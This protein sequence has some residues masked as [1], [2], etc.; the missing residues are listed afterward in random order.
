MGTPFTCLQRIY[1]T[2]KIWRDIPR[3][4]K[5]IWRY[6]LARFWRMKRCDIIV[7][8]SHTY[9]HTRI[10]TLIH[11]YYILVYIHT[12]YRRDFGGRKGVMYRVIF[13]VVNQK[14]YLTRTHMHIYTRTCT[15]E[16]IHT[17]TCAIYTRTY[18]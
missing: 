5:L 7:N 14:V 15:H 11:T 3:R 1:A 2:P 10:H 12:I 16:H 4:S 9:T 6:F 13:F 8:G 17:S 18:I